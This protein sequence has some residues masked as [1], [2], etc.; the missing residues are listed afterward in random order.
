MSDRFNIQVAKSTDFGP[1]I[2]TFT[3]VSSLLSLTNS[4]A[5]PCTPS[6]N[7]STMSWSQI[8]NN[9]LMVL[10]AEPLFKIFDLVVWVS[11]NLI[12]T[13]D[14]FCDSYEF[15][16]PLAT[17]SQRWAW[18]SS[19]T[20][21][22]SKCIE[23][24]YIWAD[25]SEGKPVQTC[26]MTRTPE[27]LFWLK[28]LRLL[29]NHHLSRRLLSLISCWKLNITARQTSGTIPST[30]VSCLQPADKVLQ[31]CAKWIMD[32]M[33][34]ITYIC[35]HGHSRQPVKTISNNSF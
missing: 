17:L 24:S 21:L 25:L 12:F 31:Y 16:A 26:S 28:F 8:K 13:D 5:L 1:L 23:K 11:A 19:A 20:I 18:L 34:K 7:T 10:R 33:A 4:S 14:D 30:R 9:W 35:S 2:L 32:I 27:S 15:S 29:L 6:A 3:R 22:T